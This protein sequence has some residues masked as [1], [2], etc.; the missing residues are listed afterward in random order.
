MPETH[1]LLACLLAA[2]QSFRRVKIT[3]RVYR[4]SHHTAVFNCEP[5]AI[6][7]E[8]KKVLVLLKDVM[9]LLGLV[10]EILGNG[11]VRF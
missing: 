9:S 2:D 1:C 11:R 8:R 5:Q 7:R 3:C 4:L 10:H 6:K